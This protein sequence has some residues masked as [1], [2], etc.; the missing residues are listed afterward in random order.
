MKVMPKQ[1][2]E[3][4]QNC[5]IYHFGAHPTQTENLIEEIICEIDDIEFSPIDEKPFKY[6]F[7]IT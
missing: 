5:L 6:N 3:V 7:T 4:S 1:L 2:L